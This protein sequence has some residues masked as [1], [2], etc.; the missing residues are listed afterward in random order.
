[1][2][3]STSSSSSVAICTVNVIATLAVFVVN[4]LSNY[5]DSR[6]ANPWGGVPIG[7]VSNAYPTPITPAGYTFAIWALIY[8]GLA[9]YAIA[10]CIYPETFALLSSANARS[11]RYLFLIAAVLNIV[12][13]VCFTRAVT[14]AGKL[15]TG[16]VQASTVIL[17]LLV[18]ALYVFLSKLL[19][20]LHATDTSLPVSTTSTTTDVLSY[21]VTHHILSVV[22]VAAFVMYCAWTT[23]ATVL[24][25]WTASLAG[26]SAPW[27]ATVNHLAI[28]TLVVLG[29]AW[30]VAIWLAKARAFPKLATGMGAAV[31]VWATVG[32]GVNASGG[33]QMSA[34]VMA[35]VVAIVA[36]VKLV[37]C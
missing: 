14:P 17:A 5:K 4:G 2:S 22:V 26:K 32:V 10:Q 1:M 30:C 23:I 37:A 16:Y 13:V 8:L 35:A 15:H 6:G 18:A 27:S 36:V 34:F 19:T 24:N 3:A 7:D 33:V 31:F 9:V 25:I 21:A 12:W 20:A 28:A 29:I 11:D